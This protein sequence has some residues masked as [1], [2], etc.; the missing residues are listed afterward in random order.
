MNENNFLLYEVS[1]RGKNNFFESHS[2]TCYG[3]NKVFLYSFVK[4][5]GDGAMPFKIQYVCFLCPEKYFLPT[6]T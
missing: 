4:L 6:F 3:Q 2:V 5:C 1:A